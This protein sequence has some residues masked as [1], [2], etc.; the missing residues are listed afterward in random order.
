MKRAIALMILGGAGTAS[1]DK[2]MSAEL[3][4]AVAVSDVQEQAFRPG[5]MPALG[6]YLSLGSHFAVGVRGRAGVLRDRVAS[7]LGG[8]RMDISTGGLAT[9]GL[10]GR[11]IF[12]GAYFE[13]VAGG[14]ITGSDVVPT[15]EGGIGYL[16]DFEHVSVGPSAR[17]ARVQATSSDA[18]GSADLLLVGVDFQFGHEH[19]RVIPREPEVEVGLWTPPAPPAP[20][21][22]PRVAYDADKIADSLPSC[23]DLLEYLDNASGCGPDGMI[24]VAGDRIILDERVLFDTDHA[25]VHSEGRAMIRAI[26][27]AATQHSEWV[28]LTIEGHADERGTDAYN[29]SLSEAR[30]ERVRDQMVKAG[31]AADKIKTVGYGRSRPRVQG[32]T[33]EA[34]H[35]NRRVEFVIDRAAHTVGVTP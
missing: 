7:P 28:M 6:A 11:V 32:S 10:A 3:P 13:L 29:Q 31:F 17:Y 8:N 25:H 4:T 14:G 2:W 9:A 30:A 23:A 16:F 35:R 24:E 19:H 26:V 27:K 18:L 1:A 20:A 12:G 15:F 34:L 5:A 33:P 21:P 22:E